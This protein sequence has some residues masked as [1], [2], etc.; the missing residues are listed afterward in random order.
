MIE[1]FSVRHHY[2]TTSRKQMGIG[3]FAFSSV[4][5]KE[6]CKEL[7]QNA[8]YTSPLKLPKNPTQEEIE[9]LFPICYTYYRLKSSGKLVLSHSKYTGRT[10]H[11]PD[12]FGNFI[13]HSI[14][15]DTVI[16]NNR[17]PVLIKNL[18]FRQSLTI[19]EEDSFLIDPEDV[20]IEVSSNIIN[21]IL[22]QY[23]LFLVEKPQY[24]NTFCLVVDT[25]IDGWLNKL[26]TNITICGSSNEVQN[27]LF[28][29]YLFL[30]KSLINR[31]T[32]STYVD[33]PS[34]YSFQLCGIIPECGIKSL[35]DKYFK[36]FNIDNYYNYEVQNEFTKYISSVIAKQ[37]NLNES[38]KILE[39]IL[40]EFN[41][42]TF[43]T[44]LNTP[45]NTLK[46][47]DNI[48]QETIDSF[49]NLL[50]NEISMVQREKL[51]E[52]V[53]VR[54]INLYFEY[55]V[56]KFKEDLRFKYNFKEKNSLFE[57]YYKQYF[58]KNHDF[59]ESHFYQFC[60][61]FKS[62]LN[63]I[64]TFNFS[65]T[66]I[67]SFDS[68]RFLNKDELQE[69]IINVNSYFNESQNEEEFEKFFLKYGN[70]ISA[71]HQ[72]L[73]N[74]KVKRELLIQIKENKFF[75]YIEKNEEN[76][77]L[78]SLNDRN[79]LFTRAIQSKNI[80]SQF[81]LSFGQY[82]PLIE[83]FFTEDSKL[84]WSYFFKQEESTTNK[85]HSLSYLK[86]HFIITVFSNIA[87]YEC[88]KGLPLNDYEKYWLLEFFKEKG[89]LKSYDRLSPLINYN[90]KG[91]EKSYFW[92]L[93][94]K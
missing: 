74:M 76:I 37:Y 48:A 78:L 32:F 22:A 91:L 50:K 85:S 2:Y 72:N 89:D 64:D 41:I 11:T 29:L 87:Y 52:Y 34:K 18:Q 6:E 12:R 53:S 9:I 8:T 79:K 46:F 61:A 83:K 23:A 73:I 56:Y 55:I 62:F 90:V 20:Q 94:K 81:D 88:I 80:I 75:E 71:S 38:I 5:S 21:E 31:I 33:N 13:T 7:E 19:E 58:S 16:L 59:F 84:F 17:I 65:Y 27:L 40:T 15:F 82:I 43:S 47:R 39:T 69:E 93:W 1:N 3:S 36:L 45:I 92:G 25:L 66:L 10:N 67:T 24:L 44:K 28:S 49:I 30:P 70:L 51:I 54:N 35:D 57:N 86:R 26:G 14:L 68:S 60:M 4:I 63:E 77:R 42:N